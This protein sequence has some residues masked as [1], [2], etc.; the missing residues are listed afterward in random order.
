MY[1]FL[2][3]VLTSIQ[4][5]GQNIYKPEYL[6]FTDGLPSDAVFMTVKKDGF[7]YVATQRGLSL[8]DGYTF[9]NSKELPNSILNITQKD[10]KIYGEEA[11]TGLF[12]IKDIYSKKNVIA[13][14]V[15]T[16]ASADNDHYSNI[17]KDDSGNIWCSDFHFLKFYNPKKNQHKVFRIT[18]DNKQLDIQISYIETKNALIAATTKGL[19]VWDKQREIFF[20]KSGIRF[21]SAVT[22]HGKIFLLSQTGQLFEYILNKSELKPMELLP[23]NQ[24]VFA[25]KDYK[26]KNHNLLLYDT[27]KVFLYET[28][29]KKLKEI[30]H[31]DYRIN[32]VMYDN[33]A[34]QI[35]LSTQKGLVKLSA[36]KGD[37]V[38]QQLPDLT[39]KPA[40]DIVQ[41]G[42]EIWAVKN[43]G[44]FFKKEGKWEQYPLKVK[45]A[46]RLSV[47]DNKLI[48]SADDGVYE[49]SEK[50]DL[51]KIIR[52]DYPVKKT[53]FHDG[54]YWLLPEYGSIRVFDGKTFTEIPDYVKNDKKFSL[55][56]YFN[57]FVVADG[58]LWLASWMPQDFGISYFSKENQRFE[59]ITKIP[60]NKS[61]FVADFFN[62]AVKLRNG[63]V[64]FSSTG[65]F[66]IVNKEGKI[67]HKMETRENKIANDNIMGI[68]EDLQGNIWFG[69]AEGL[70]Q[71]N[72]QTK[73]AVRISKADGLNSNDLV[74]GF[75]LAPQNNLYVSDEQSL[76]KINLDRIM[77]TDLINDLKLTAIKVNNEFLPSISKSISLKEK[78]ASQIDYYFS[79]LNYTGKDKLIYRYKFDDDNE[80]HYLGSVPKLSLVKLTP[81]KYKITV[82]V[83]DNLG[84]R[85][86]KNLEL[87]LN[88]IPPFHKTVWF[89]LLLFLLFAAIA[90]G[91]NR[92]LVLQEKQKGILKKKMKENENKMLRSQMNP[93][94]LFNSLNSINSFIIQHKSDEAERYLTSFSKLMRN[95]LDNSRKENIS[96]RQELDTIKLYLD[97]EAVRMDH[98]FDYRIH[99]D[100]S[101]DSDY[102]QIPP[103]ILQPFLENA[104]WHGINH[105]KDKGF[106][107]INIK[108][109]PTDPQM[110][111]IEIKDDG[112][113]RKASSGLKKSESHK[114]HGLAITEE[115]LKTNDPE[116]SVEITDLYDQNQKPEGTKVTIK[117]KMSH[118]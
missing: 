51:K 92:F 80:W 68:G 114:C 113:G 20:K 13:K 46:G 102:V 28:E 2:L 12:E 9:V 85:Q 77:K 90:F 10:N 76:E 104:I 43:S 19:F 48:F 3:T 100:R 73:T 36:G 14:V 57:D 30:Y 82:E 70:Y 25:V 11:G 32:H 93:H 99:V 40:S 26:E 31:S 61:E 107:E 29:K 89:Y 42:E 75:Y 33:Q 71:Y 84:N 78:D 34:K 101:V 63:N 58:K 5:F 38:T 24:P 27:E 106:I 60:G 81:G 55:I 65:G 1:R 56:N 16:D 47:S 115:R 95:I 21:I 49:K 97:L 18:N 54:K 109:D 37:I 118:D 17:Y 7:L 69:C 22:K 117:I 53:V 62:R 96:L 83:G 66:N 35:W 86:K 103:L 15:F 112:I 98:K 41:F 39:K 110:L 111:L 64:I 59:Q 23:V 105:K 50:S 52:T 44:L 87:L 4:L 8:Y 91:V 88:I 67:V 6:Q 79:A 45:T 94:F 72:L 116:N 108:D 74:Y